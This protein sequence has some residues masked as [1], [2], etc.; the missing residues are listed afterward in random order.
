MLPSDGATEL[1]SHGLQLSA[2]FSSTSAD[3]VPVGQSTQVAGMVLS[4]L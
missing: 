4:S 3:V 2:P 1:S